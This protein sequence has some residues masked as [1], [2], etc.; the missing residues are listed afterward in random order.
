MRKYKEAM[1]EQAEYFGLDNRMLQCTEELGELIQA[2]SK[3]R[4]AID[5]DGTCT[6]NRIEA[7]H[8]VAEEMA[9]V[10]ICIKQLKHLLGNKNQ[11]ERIR[12]QKVVRTKQRLLNKTPCEL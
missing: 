11:V 7:E 8:M 10:E 3:Y 12:E 1:K 2:L 4:R 6:V 9:D 5:G